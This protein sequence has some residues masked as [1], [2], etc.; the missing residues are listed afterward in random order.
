M[1]LPSKYYVLIDVSYDRIVAETCYNIPK[2][3]SW[4]MMLPW[5]RIN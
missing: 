5:Q 2:L 3:L 4:R 1:G